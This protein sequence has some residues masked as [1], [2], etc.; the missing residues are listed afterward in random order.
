[1]QRLKTYW[2]VIA[3]VL[4]AIVKIAL[5]VN[6]PLNVHAGATYDDVWALRAADF[7]SSGQWLGPYDSTTLI[8]NI[9]FPLYLAACIKVGA[10]YLLPTALLYA[11]AT[12]YFTVALR[13]LVKR[14]W[15]LFV[16]FLLVLFNPVSLS[17]ETFQRLYRNSITAAQV[18]LV[19]GS[20]IGV[21]AR[22]KSEEGPRVRF[23]I[24]WILVG[25]VSL[26]W[27]WITREDSIW[28]APFVLV[29]TVLIC[30]VLLRS[31]MQKGLAITASILM[32]VPVVCT[33]VAV[34]AV[35]SMNQAQYGMYTLAEINEGNFA[36]MIKDLYAIAPDEPPANQRV[37]CT[38]GSLERAYAASNS[39]AR[40]KSQVENRFFRW[41]DVIDSDPG[42]GEVNGGEFFWVLRLAANDAGLY[43]SA[44]DIDAFY[45]KVADE[46]EGAFS[47]GKLSRRQTMP[48]SIM[49]PWRDEYAGELPNAI[50][51]IYM[52]AATLQDVSVAPSPAQGPADGVTY[53]ERLAGNKGYE[54]GAPVPFGCIAAE[55]VA[56]LYKVISPALALVGAIAYLIL[57]V[58]WLLARFIPRFSRNTGPL[59]LVLSALAL[60]SFTLV[61]GL[62]Y[63]LISSFVPIAYY[64][65]G[66][67]LYP[68][69]T[70]F[71]AC[72]IFG[73]VNAF[74]RTGGK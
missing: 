37:A 48:S 23:L 56:W 35:R 69:L 11:I 42:D 26:A 64:Y 57:L 9:G 39:L 6:M 15:M 16:L 8:K 61:C 49:S 63:S 45:G 25:A 17:T 18:L 68:L 71:C 41:G 60:G 24:V 53:F 62:A 52:Q 1:M 59:V 38:H 28:I 7:L 50:A 31:D 72:S 36:R 43:T 19:F 44:P 51:N 40:I 3:C 33:G 14:D 66:V 2:L 74:G 10:G 30:V 5:S 54:Q 4:A 58:L 67:A 20:Y 22:V 70:A 21:Y 29:A 46:L 32:L 47:A 12:A 13:P 73:L 34:H 55:G 65:Y 27:F